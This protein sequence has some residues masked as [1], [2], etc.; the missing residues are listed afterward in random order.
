MHMLAQVGQPHAFVL[1]KLLAK[2]GQ[3][4]PHR[5]V[6]VVVVLELLQRRQQRVP[7]A[8]GDTNGEEDEKAVK[9][10]FF[11]D[12]AMLGQEL[13]HDAGRNAGLGKLAIQ[14]QP[15]RDNGGLDRIQHVEAGGHL[16]K[17]VPVIGAVLGG[18]G[19]ARLALDDPV[20]GASNALFHQLVRSPD[21][22]PPVGFV[23]LGNLAHRTAEIQRFHNAFFHQRG[24]AGW[25]HHGSSHVAAGNDAVLRAG[26]GVHQVSLVEEMPVQLGV[27]RILHQHLAGLA[28]TGQQLVNRLGGVDHRIFWADAIL[29][30][31]VV[32]A[33]ERMEGRVR[34]PG[35]IK[36]QVVDVAVEH[37]LDGFG[38]VH[39]AVVGGL[40]QR[41]HAG[42]DSVGINTLEQRIGGNL[43]ADGIGLELALRNRANDAE[44][45][46]RRLQKHRNRA[47]HDDGVQ[48]GLV[49]VAVHHHHVAGRHR[50]VP[51]HLV[52]GRGAVG[53][54][55]T[56]V[57]IEDARRVALRGSDRTGVIE[58]LAELF[59]R[60]AHVRAQ[61]VLA[62]ELVVHLADRAFQERH[63][64]R[65]TGAVP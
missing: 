48:D 18:L 35:F 31:R 23:F 44:V 65:V 14:V 57:G 42:L 27:L 58:Q 15:R 38:V 4:A 30:H 20:C 5:L 17:A 60:V 26:A 21:L 45:V 2:L 49:A 9:A 8:L 3:D 40:R 62:V 24:A 10:G 7:A 1:G 59:Y 47:G 12:H 54:E 36:M 41:Q 33:V 19:A 55:K 46:T 64:A 11:N 52:A 43:G 22:E 50:V 6:L 37:A 13:G 53:H 39:H 51:D 56:V 61:H 25:L 29:A 63:A 28:D 34:Q 16:A 32:S